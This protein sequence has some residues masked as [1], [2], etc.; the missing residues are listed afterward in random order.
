[1]NAEISEA[2]QDVIHRVIG[3]PVEAR[4]GQY[5]PQRAGGEAGECFHAAGGGQREPIPQQGGEPHLGEQL[6]GAGIG[7]PPGQW[8]HVGQ[9]FV[10]I[11]HDHAR[12]RLHSGSSR[13]RQAVTG[14]SHVAAHQV[15]G[16]RRHPRRPAHND[17]SYT[18]D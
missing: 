8:C 14:A 6:R 11:E 10:D 2:S 13:Y 9:G 17:T 15:P 5:R 16:R 18:V 3:R 12:T 1:M 4:S 7:E